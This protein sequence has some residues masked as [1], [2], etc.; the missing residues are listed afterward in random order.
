MGQEKKKTN[1]IKT[2]ELEVYINGVKNEEKNRNIN[3]IFLSLFVI[4]SMIG[5]Y[6]IIN[7][8]GNSSLDNKK[9]I[10]TGKIPN[11]KEQQGEQSLKKRNVEN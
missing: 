6:Y 7:N 11:N 9:Q 2:Q 10:N 1:G 3:R 8:S 5:V 4:F